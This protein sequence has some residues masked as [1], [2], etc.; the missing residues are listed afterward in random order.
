MA[1]KQPMRPRASAGKG[2]AFPG[3][4]REWAATWQGRAAIVA[5][6][7]LILGGAYVSWTLRDLP[8]PN[9][10]LFAHSIVLF[11]RKGREIQQRN[12]N[13]EHLHIALPED[14]RKPG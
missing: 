4:L 11:D 5:G 1:D 9:K 14:M 6:I 13:G 8:D 7:V 10:P 12:A 2:F 3:N